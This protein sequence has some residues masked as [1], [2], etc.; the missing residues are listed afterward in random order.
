MP[1]STSR[2]HDPVQL[3][4]ASAL[5]VVAV[6]AQSHAALPAGKP[7]RRREREAAAVAY[8]HCRTRGGPISPARFLP[9]HRALTRAAVLLIL[10]LAAPAAARAAVVAGAA[11]QPSAVHPI[12]EP[13]TSL[14]AGSGL[15][16]IYDGPAV[17]SRFMVPVGVAEAPDGSVL[18]ADAGAQDIRRIAQSVVTTVA[19]LAPNG[20]TAD[21]RAGGFADGPAST[22]RFDRPVGVA[23]ATNGDVFVADAGNRCIRKIARGIVS[24]FSGSRAPG[25]AD[26]DARIAQFENPKGLAIDDEGVLYVADYGA[27]IRRV[28]T[29]GSVTTL[30]R[31]NDAK[32]IVAIA[33]RGGGPQALIAYAD[34]RRL[35]LYANG[36]WQDVAY[37][38]LR[39]PGATPLAVG[40][41]A[42]IAIL[43]ENTL[44]VADAA[45]NAVRLVRFPAPPF[46]TDKMARVL[47]GGVR[48]GDDL[49]GGYASG[50]P[51]R[52]LVKSPRGIALAHDG[53]L[54]VAD[55]GNRRIRAIQNVDARESIVPGGAN[56]ALPRGAYRIAVVGNSYAYYNVLWPESI[57]GRI[58]ALLTQDARWIGLRARPALCVFRVDDLS[59]ASGESL[60]REYLGD[61]QVDLVVLLLN[62]YGPWDADQLA[63]VQ[64]T[65]L[66]KGTRLMIVYTPQG[67]EVS[68]LDYPDGD[69]E[70]NVD[71]KDLR[72][73]AIKSETFYNRTGIPNALLLDEMEAFEAA[74]VHK[75]LFYA[76][77]HHFTIFGSTWV[78]E[79]I[80][81]AIERWHPWSLH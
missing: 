6:R 60:I 78:G 22:A 80:A 65:L 69:V 37:T 77:D 62:A 53:T 75:A 68:P 12:P 13:Y 23:V 63:R 33:V 14:L 31:P 46:V 38:D 5:I 29:D 20:S 79:H 44:A 41:A 4:H 9:P 67:F 64:R 35:H 42:G 43:N 56:V 61:G 10:A 48:E 59:A 40:H 32:T 25:H 74:P 55:T 28:A 57:P 26:G 1:T 47:A 49:G 16:G 30:P 70:R 73:E 71:F 8:G 66:A 18:V 7:A 76:G 24:T 52:S 54:I 81:A 11:A 17:V 39:E 27:G 15:R 2:Q 19:G 3:P 72:A 34:E 45:T 50:S 21:E 58:E 36:A 51:E